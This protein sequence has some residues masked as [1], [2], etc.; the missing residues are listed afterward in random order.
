MTLESDRT[1][2]MKWKEQ[3]E[4]I[5]ALT[6]LTQDNESEDDLTSPIRTAERESSECGTHKVLTQKQNSFE[7]FYKDSLERH[8]LCQKQA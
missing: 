4:K 2:M 5:N 3:Q 7:D 6:S 8:Q 1:V